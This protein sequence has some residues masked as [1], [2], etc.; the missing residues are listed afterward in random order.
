MSSILTRN[1]LEKGYH[2]GL[3]ILS[4]PENDDLWWDGDFTHFDFD[5]VF[6]EI[7]TSAPRTMAD[8]S[9]KEMKWTIK[10]TTQ[11]EP[12]GWNESNLTF[13]SDFFINFLEEGK[14]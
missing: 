4:P 5:S 13:F 3:G 2:K 12:V 1:S 9:F 8:K 11:N 10:S 6:R 7:G 14:S